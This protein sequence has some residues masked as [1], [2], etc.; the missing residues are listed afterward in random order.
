MIKVTSTLDDFTTDK[1][2]IIGLTLVWHTTGE[3]TN[4]EP[5]VYTRVSFFLL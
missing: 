5:R 1:V 4:D 3:Y 2:N